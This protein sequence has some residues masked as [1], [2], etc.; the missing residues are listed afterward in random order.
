MATLN[1]FIHAPSANISSERRLPSSIPIHQL[2]G[3]L[4]RITGIPPSEQI[5]SL[6][7]TRT[8]DPDSKAALIARLP[9]HGEEAEER[10]LEDFH[11]SEGMAI[12]VSTPC[13]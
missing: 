3:H 8:D 12:K 4:E 5:L 2:K 13:V 11:A 7:S 1:L 9:A 6:H 10:S